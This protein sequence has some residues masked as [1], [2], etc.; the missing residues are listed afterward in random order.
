MD[1]STPIAGERQD[2]DLTVHMPTQIFAGVTSHVTRRLDLSAAVRWTDSS[3]FADSDIEFAGISLQ[4]V[5]DGKDE[6]RVAGGASFDVTDRLVLR[7]GLSY[8]TRVVG[9]EGISPG[10]FDDEDVKVSAGF[11][12]TTGAWTL[13]TMGGYAFDIDRT[14]SADKAF[15]IPGSYRSEAGIVMLGVTWQP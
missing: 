12:W 11:S 3:T 10:L 2:V 4:F 15:V 6:W 13:H 9:N 5:P 7:T 8:A 14:V 1:G